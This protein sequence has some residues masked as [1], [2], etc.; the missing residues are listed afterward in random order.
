MS[1][2]RSCNG[3]VQMDDKG[4]IIPMCNLRQHVEKLESVLGVIADFPPSEDNQYINWL[5]RQAAE[6]IGVKLETFSK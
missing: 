2:N 6:A 5:R 3:I 1:R 4:V